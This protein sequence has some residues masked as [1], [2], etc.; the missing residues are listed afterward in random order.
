MLQG[1]RGTEDKDDLSTYEPL[2]GN[3]AW[4][5]FRGHILSIPTLPGWES[6]PEL[7]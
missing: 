6:F 4:G 7:R 3:R 2:D 1:E 5:H